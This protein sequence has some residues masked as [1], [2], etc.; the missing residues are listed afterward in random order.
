MG[1]DEFQRG[2]IHV[3]HAVLA[4]G[5]VDAEDAEVGKE[6]EHPR[7]GERGGDG[8]GVVLLD[9]A[10]DQLLGEG[11]RE[12]E[13]ADGFQQIAIQRGDGSSGLPA[14]ATARSYNASPKAARQSTGVPGR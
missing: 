6:G 2:A 10:F 8:G 1:S 7:A 9:A 14:L 4:V 3:A 5:L 13:Q 12:F 11:A